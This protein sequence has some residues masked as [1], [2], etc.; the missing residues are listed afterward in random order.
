M[1]LVPRVMLVINCYAKTWC[2]HLL[3]PCFVAVFVY[4]IKTTTSVGHLVFTTFSY[5]VLIHFVT[6][7]TF[8]QPEPF[9][10]VGVDL[11]LAVMNLA[12]IQCLS[13]YLIAPSLMS[14]GSRGSGLQAFGSYLG[15][16]SC[17]AVASVGLW[18]WLTF[19]TQLVAEIKMRRLLLQQ[20]LR[21]LEQWTRQNYS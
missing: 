20:E 10:W 13:V 8:K 6:R 19:R 18:R 3:T 1:P 16:C 2:V 14:V 9:K 5:N 11:K 15:L 4:A 7:R 12:I 21:L 17:I